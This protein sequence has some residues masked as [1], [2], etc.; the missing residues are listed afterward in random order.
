[1]A[2]ALRMAGMP[3]GYIDSVYLMLKHGIGQHLLELVS[4]DG[5]G[6][7]RAMTLYR[8]GITNKEELLKDEKL[9]TNALGAA[10]YKR[11]RQS[12]EKPGSIFVP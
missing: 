3:G 7:K 4:L 11:V 10:L 6:R 8:F 1:M 9:G 2:A 12:I 5:I